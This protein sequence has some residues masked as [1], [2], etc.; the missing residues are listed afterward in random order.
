M[1]SSPSFSFKKRYADHQRLAYSIASIVALLIL[2][3]SVVYLLMTRQSLQAQSP[4]LDQL[5]YYDLTRLQRNDTL[6]ENRALW[7][8]VGDMVS[9]N[10]QLQEQAQ[11]YDRYRQELSLPYRYFLHYIYTPS[12]NIR[13]DSFSNEIDTTLIGEKY[14]EK[15]PYNDITL[16]QKRT[17]FFKDMGNIDQ[18]NTIT[19]ITIGA[20]TPQSGGTFFGIPL[21]VQFE[22]P[23]RRSF[24]LLVN[25]LSMT[26]YADNVSLMSEFMYNLWD[27]IKEERKEII[28]AELAWLQLSGVQNDD[29]LI[30]YTLYQRIYADASIDTLLDAS[31]I[32]K[33]IAQTA[34]CH[35]QSSEECLYLFR[36]KYRSIPYL[37]Y[38]IGRPGID[39]VLGLR[40][41]LR[42]LPPLI[43]IDGFSFDLK[44][45]RILGRTYDTGYKWS[46]S[47]TVFGKDV[48]PEDMQEIASL[49][50]KKCFR[51]GEAM[52]I[53][54]GA[55]RVEQ[56]IDQLG[57]EDINITRSNRL[58]DMKKY[59]A[60]MLVSYESLPYYKKVIRLFEVYRTL[61]EWNACDI[62][63]EESFQQSSVLPESGGGVESGASVSENTTGI[64]VPTLLP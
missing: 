30:G 36:D 23:D 1:P 37:A 2:L 6:K 63:V 21:T 32:N 58:Q 57:G 39:T 43:A 44:T 49:L 3:W 5:R 33:A 64:V 27:V 59:F 11:S 54:Q 25:K 13:K 9:Y 16:I 56:L 34:W 20:I 42:E 22:T 15:N 31:L 55:Q 10:D 12:L 60:D 8:T 4:E 35:D 53:E 52:S 7:Q 26:S 45:R 50:G 62:V 29:A 47:L 61:L 51:G 41:F 18:Y 24:L 19:N 14:L 38:G 17:D 48:T 28:Q 46:I 40:E